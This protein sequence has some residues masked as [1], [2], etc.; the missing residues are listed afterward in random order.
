MTDDNETTSFFLPKSETEHFLYAQIRDGSSRDKSKTQIESFWG[1]YR[2]HAPKRFLHK[3]QVD[4]Y[5]RWWEMFLSVGL[6]NLNFEINTDKE[7]RGPDIKVILPNNKVV[8]IEA[9]APNIGNNEEAVPPLRN[10][11]SDLPEKEFLLRLHKALYDEKLFKFRKFR[12]KGLINADDHCIIALSAC[13]L[14]QYGNLMDHPVP[15][16]LKVL[17]CAGNLVLSEKGNYVTC[18]EKIETNNERKVDMSL[19]NMTDF[20]RI[21]AVLY[22]NIDILNSPNT[23]ES[24]FQLFLNPFANNPI[25]YASF[26]TIE[27]WFEESRNESQVVWRVINR[28]SDN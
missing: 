21:S 20:S 7:D 15:A 18:H 3:A 16:P 23:P 10:G 4:F 5:Q 1:K 19:F 6:L 12:N 2:I 27:T 28:S 26:D 9:I 22:S 24:S 17:A 13:A 8:W 14:A 11:V 25:G